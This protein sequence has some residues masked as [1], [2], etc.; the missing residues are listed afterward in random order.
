[1]IGPKRALHRIM[2]TLSALVLPILL[3]LIWNARHPGPGTSGASLPQTILTL[4]EP[5]YPQT[6]LDGK[7]NIGVLQNGTTWLLDVR[8]Q[9]SLKLPDVLMYL[10]H[11]DSSMLLGEIGS[12]P[13]RQYPLPEGVEPPNFSIRLYSLAHYETLYEVSLTE[14]TP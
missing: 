12:Q 1:M 7:L 4:G 3:V 8:K 10:D 13:I 14:V 2:W 9:K 5:Q 6:L 11:A